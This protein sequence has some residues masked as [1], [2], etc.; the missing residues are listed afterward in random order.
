MSPK[1]RTTEVSGQ[2][3][4]L[5]SGFSRATTTASASLCSG[6]Q[7]RD[8]TAAIALAPDDHSLQST[9][10]APVA[11]T[12]ARAPAPCFSIM[13]RGRESPSQ[14]KAVARAAQAAVEPPAV[15]PQGENVPA[16]PQAA[17]AALDRLNAEQR[18]AATAPIQPSMIL[19]GAGTGKTTTLIARI[20]HLL[21]AGI[22]PGART[23][24]SA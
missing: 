18:A 21:E 6:P 8:L 12:A 2:S 10:T 15:L 23:P 9:A 17:P 19:A 3:S 22:R 5:A 13:P 24:P 11:P 7:Q 14:Q 1:K 4:L 16:P 20:N